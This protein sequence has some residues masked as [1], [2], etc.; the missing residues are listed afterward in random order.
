MAGAGAGILLTLLGIPAWLLWRRRKKAA[1]TIAAQLGGV[2]GKAIEGPDPHK[3]FEAR[4]AEQH[5]LKDQQTRDAL[6]SL[7]LPPVK[8]KKTEVLAKHISEE[9]KKDPTVMAQV[10]RTWLNTSDYER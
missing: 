4:I 1:A 5:A 3:E 7:K 8:T 9:A 6:N 10:I 2:D